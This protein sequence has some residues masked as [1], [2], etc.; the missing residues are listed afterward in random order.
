M[1][2]EIKDYLH[3]YL[4]CE[5]LF[6]KCSYHFVH[7]LHI[8][9]GGRV[10]LTTKLLYNISIGSGI[11]VKPLLRLPSD[12]TKEE[13]YELCQ[14]MD[15]RTDGNIFNEIKMHGIN[16]IDVDLKGQAEF[17]RILLSKYFDLF[18]LIESGLAINETK[19]SI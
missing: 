18:G 3:H 10:K 15:W 13:G 16:G 11:V 6:E 1:K 4:G 2:K 7:K 14:L 17:F 5:V 12:M 19:Q 8:H 9:Q